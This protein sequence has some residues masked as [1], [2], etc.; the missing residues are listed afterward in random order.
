MSAPKL[1]AVGC[2]SNRWIDHSRFTFGTTIIKGVKNKTPTEFVR[3]VK[4]L[5]VHV[6]M[7]N[8]DNVVDLMRYFPCLEKLYFKCCDWDT[9][10]LWRR[11]YRNLF[12]SI[13]IR[14]KTV[15]L[16]NYRGIWSQV[17]FAQFFVVSARVLESMKFVVSPKDYHK[18]FVAEQRKMLQLDKKASRGAHF[19]FTTDRSRYGE[20]DIEHVQNLS[21]TDPFDCRCR[22]WFDH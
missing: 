18:G 11:K 14:L 13:D 22:N 5:A 2:L 9:K 15:V 19:Y 6:V 4:I 12:K 17:H 7:L 1:E 8:V 10:N 16:E 20:S 21:C 3:N